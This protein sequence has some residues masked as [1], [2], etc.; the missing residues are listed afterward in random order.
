MLWLSA[1][2]LAGTPWM[3]PPDDVLAVLNA[4]EI[5]VVQVNP[6]RDLLLLLTPVRYPPLADKAAPMV[7]VAG[8][9]I[10]PRTN[11]FHGVS[12][13]VSPALLSAEGGEIRPLPLPEGLRVLDV[14]WT[15]DGD[16]FALEV[17]HPDHIGLWVGDRTGALEEIETVRLNPLLGSELEWTS[18]GKHLLV[19]IVDPDRGPEPRAPETPEGPLVKDAGGGGTAA[20]TYEARDLLGSPFDEAQFSWFARSRV[21]VVDPG[22][23]TVTPLGEA[24]PIAG[25]SMSPDGRYVLVQRL[26]PP[27]SY[28]TAWVRFS[29][30]LEVWSAKGALVER[31]ASLP[32]EDSVPTHGVPEGI[33]DLRWRQSADATLVWT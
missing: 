28:T 16:R 26:T 7:K 13:A 14:A 24:G 12:G 22:Q 11:G 9:R 32:V 10:N 27:W 23:E 1:L 3:H 31:I 2:A 4:P 5:P 19:K 20:S 17:G 29:R 18:N 30:D 6:T 21:A 15:A 25:V 33:R 8:L